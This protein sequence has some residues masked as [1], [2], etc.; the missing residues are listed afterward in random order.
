MGWEEKRKPTKPLKVGGRV[1]ANR[2]EED[3][4]LGGLADVAGGGNRSGSLSC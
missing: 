3:R 2:Q 4:D 1:Q